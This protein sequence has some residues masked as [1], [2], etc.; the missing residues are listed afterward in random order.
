[1]TDPNQPA[2]NTGPDGA[3]EPADA[4]APAAGDPAAAAPDAPTAPTEPIAEKTEGEIAEITNEVRKD[5]NEQ[6]ALERHVMNAGD[7]G[8]SE[9]AEDLDREPVEQEAAPK[10]KGRTPRLALESAA[11]PV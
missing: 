7:H 11:K 5:Q 2:P 10:N 4:V 1:M 9:H 8:R 6:R 3:N